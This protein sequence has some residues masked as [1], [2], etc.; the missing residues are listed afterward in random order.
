MRNEAHTLNIHW[1]GSNAKNDNTVVSTDQNDAYVDLVTL[2]NVDANT[3]FRVILDF[4][5]AS[6][7]CTNI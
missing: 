4:N 2:S 6:S 3:A 5:Y 1:D 7:P